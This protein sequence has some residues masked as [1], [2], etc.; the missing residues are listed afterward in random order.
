[1]V[2]KQGEINTRLSHEELNTNK[3]VIHV[4]EESLKKVAEIYT[5]A[6][7]KVEEHHH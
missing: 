7:G 3:N 2:E 4:S 1:V 5:L 6:G